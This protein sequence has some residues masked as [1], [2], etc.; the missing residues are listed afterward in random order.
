MQSNSSSPHIDEAERK[1]LRAMEQKKELDEDV[2]YLWNK[3]ENTSR[4]VSDAYSTV[5]EKMEYAL[6]HLDL[7]IGLLE[8]MSTGRAS[9]EQRELEALFEGDVENYLHSA[10]WKWCAVRKM[11]RQLSAST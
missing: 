9:D 11:E 1:L 7:R 3:V 10:S 2:A 4:Q 6:L 8:K 5:L